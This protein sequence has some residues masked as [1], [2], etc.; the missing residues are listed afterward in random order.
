[1]V[2]IAANSQGRGI[3]PGTVHEDGDDRGG[4]WPGFGDAWAT[5][6]AAVRESRRRVQEPV[7]QCFGFAAGKDGCVA[8]A[9]Q[10][11]CPGGQ[12]GRDLGEYQPGLVDVELPGGEPAQA[13]GFG[14]SDPVFDPGVGSVT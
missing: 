10:Q 1:M 4:P 7:A 14:V 11:T 5:S 8:G 6:A 12:V 3:K 9:A 2:R 13:G